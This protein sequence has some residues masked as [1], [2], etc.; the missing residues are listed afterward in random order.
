L[1]EERA[2]RDSASAR[3]EEALE[4]ADRPAQRAEIAL[5]LAWAH[6]NLFKAV[7]P[8]GVLERAIGQLDVADDALL[9][10]LEP[11]LRDVLAGEKIRVPSPW[12]STLHIRTVPPSVNQ[13]GRS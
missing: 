11:E 2:G 10:R 9:G 13:G 3:L 7:D 5:Q 8:V 4:L 12:R 6:A 1:A